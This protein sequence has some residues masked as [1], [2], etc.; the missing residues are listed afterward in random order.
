MQG[1]GF[2][3]RLCVRVKERRGRGPRFYGSWFM[4]HGVGFR[5]SGKIMLSA[6]IDAG[7][8]TCGSGHKKYGQHSLPTVTR[9][10]FLMDPRT[11]ALRGS[12][13]TFSA[14]PPN[15][16]PT[17]SRSSSPMEKALGPARLLC[18]EHHR[19]LKV[20]SS[21]ASCFRSRPR[22]PRLQVR[23]LVKQPLNLRATLTCNCL[24]RLAS[25]VVIGDQSSP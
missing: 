21:S 10:I 22:C 1:F 5:V 2:G 23:P 4:Y 9:S 8:N 6:G 11:D 16:D 12:S 7:R 17:S 3:G 13:T 19:D 20:P 25:K 15:R 18:L 24:Q 14:I